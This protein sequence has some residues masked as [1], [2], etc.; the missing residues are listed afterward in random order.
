MAE[1]QSEWRNLRRASWLEAVTLLALLFVAMPLK[2]VFGLPIATSIAGSV[3]GIAFLFFAWML[4]Q[5]IFG[6]GLRLLEALRLLVFAFLPF[7]GFYNEHYLRHRKS[8][9]A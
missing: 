8:N 1:M 3:H 9:A 4:V 2:Y 6:D 5:A 7:G